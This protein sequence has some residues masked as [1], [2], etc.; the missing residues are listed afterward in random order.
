M[1]DS[2]KSVVKTSLGGAPVNR[3]R[4]EIANDNQNSGDAGKDAGLLE[5]ISKGLLNMF[6][7]ASATTSKLPAGAGAAARG[8]S[9]SINGLPPTGQEQHGERQRSLSQEDMISP[10]DQRFQAAH[11]R[12]FRAFSHD[13]PVK[14]SATTLFHS[15]T[16]PTKLSTPRSPESAFGTARSSLP[17]E[18]QSP[19]LLDEL[20]TRLGFA[21]PSPAMS[22]GVGAPATL[23]TPSPSQRVAHQVSLPPESRQHPPASA[24]VLSDPNADDIEEMDPDERR[25]I[26]IE[27]EAE[28][29]EAAA[30]AMERAAERAVKRAEGQAR[31]AQIR[32]RSQQLKEEEQVALSS[33]GRGHISW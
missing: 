4:S 11:R 20:S 23:A 17:S 3:R 30:R 16:P 27:R 31:L 28:E 13:G 24:D 9:P 5:G 18:P 21:S 10:T 6:G 19:G 32:A 22:P 14:D 2:R 7:M 33:M 15:A 25:A 12:P 29:L 26:E 1:R 8:L